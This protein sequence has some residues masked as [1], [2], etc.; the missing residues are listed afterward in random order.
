[1]SCRGSRCR[2]LGR[3]RPRPEPGKGSEERHEPSDSALCAAARDRE[4]PRLRHGR[5]PPQDEALPAS[6]GEGL[7]LLPRGLPRE[8]PSGS[9]KVSLGRTSGANGARGGSRAR[10]AEGAARPRRRVHV[11]DASRDRAAGARFVPDLRDGPRAA[12][13]LAGRGAESRARRHE[14]AAA[15]RR[16]AHRTAA[17]LRNGSDG[18]A[19]ALDGDPAGR[20]PSR[21]MAP[22]D[23]RGALGWLALLSARLDVGEDAQSEHVHPD[24]PR[25][26]RGLHVQS[27]EDDRVPNPLSKQISFF[28]SL[29]I[30]FPR[31]RRVLRS[32]RRHH[33]SRPPRAG[34]G[35][36]RAESHRRRDPGPP[37]PRAEDG[38]AR[39]RGRRRRGRSDRAA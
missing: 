3:P 6:R 16:R 31:A 14:A 28:L 34:P 38:A 15:S 25:N 9:P 35:A 37:R 36:R 18:R 7:L 26:G 8:V 17:A 20:G 2:P 11:P 30:S 29:F 33:D 12:D 22:L 21:A 23:A 19:G 4:G 1:M 24:R 13:D 27:G 32:S 39:E 10:G 5:R